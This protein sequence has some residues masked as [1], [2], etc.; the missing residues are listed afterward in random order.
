MRKTLEEQESILFP[1][2]DAL[3]FIKRTGT[4][5][6]VGSSFF[7]AENPPFGATFTYYIK[8]VPKTKKALRQETRK[9]IS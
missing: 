4:F 2:K 6:G 8:E 5:S 9:R 1:V 3:M 7:K